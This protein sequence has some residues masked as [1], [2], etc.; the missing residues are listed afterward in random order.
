MVNIELSGT[1]V[2]TID[3]PLAEAVDLVGAFD[4]WDERRYPMHRGS[5]GRWRVALRVASGE[6][7]FRYLVDG[8]AWMLDPMAH[9][10][11]IAV[12]GALKSRV[13]R[14]PLR[15]DPDGLAA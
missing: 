1:I 6:Y 11:C 12:D 5:G 8:R 15:L 4:G 10:T 3:V 9:G 14:P 7:L 2:F 13:W